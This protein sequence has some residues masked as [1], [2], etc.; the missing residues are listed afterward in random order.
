MTISMASVLESKPARRR[1]RRDGEGI[2]AALNS[3]A[4]VSFDKVITL[5]GRLGT[6]VE[7]AGIADA[8]MKECFGRATS[9]ESTVEVLQKVL[10]PIDIEKLVNAMDTCGHTG[11]VDPNLHAR[12]ELVETPV[13][14]ELRK[15]LDEPDKI[16]KLTRQR[17]GSETE[18]ESLCLFVF[19]F[20]TTSVDLPVFH[21]SVL[22]LCF[23]LFVIP[24]LL[25]LHVVLFLILL[26]CF[27][28]RVLC[29]CAFL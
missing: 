20:S 26:L 15:L 10:L 24:F 19:S 25:L 6:L 14:L 12:D 27:V 7:K 23:F 21:L 1:T 17:S 5:E 2:N 18:S 29:V 8:S 28:P 22:C 13:K 9:L 11:D 16:S 3:L 4:Q